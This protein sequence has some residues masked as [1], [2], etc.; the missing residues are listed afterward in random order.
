M[1]LHFSRVKNGV[2]V[3]VQRQDAGRATR[4]IFYFLFKKRFRSSSGQLIQLDRS[5][6]PACTEPCGSYELR[7]DAETCSAGHLF[8]FPR[9]EFAKFPGKGLDH[10]LSILLA[11]GGFSINPNQ[12]FCI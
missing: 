8:P 1:R 6:S 10:F 4:G 5:R 2:L 9:N 3:A 7:L 11:P 12:R